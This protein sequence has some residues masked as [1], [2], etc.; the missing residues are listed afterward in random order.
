MKT[1]ISSTLCLAL[2]FAAS[3][4]K[5]AQNDECTLDQATVIRT[6][7]ALAASD[8]LVTMAD[9]AHTIIQRRRQQV[10]PAPVHHARHVSGH[11][12]LECGQH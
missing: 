2:L 4:P 7:A 8:Y 11:A 5:A 3:S 12:W 1:T 6:A 10:V 9:V